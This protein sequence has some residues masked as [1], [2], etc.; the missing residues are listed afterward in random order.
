MDK[1]KEMTERLEQ[2]MYG[3]VPYNISPIQQG[4]QF[5]HAVVEYGLENIIKND[6]YQQWARNDKTFIILN[7][8]TT[9]NN[10][11][12]Y[13]TLNNAKINLH[14]LGVEIATFHEPDLGDQLT[15][16]VFLVDE[17]IYDYAKYPTYD[18]IMHEVGET[19]YYEN[20]FGKEYEKV[21]DMRDFLSQYKLA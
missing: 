17:R 16:I 18:Y 11:E 8:G 5:G 13:G 6:A 15:A 14:S 12:R 4:I 7:G 19:T 2:R 21:L 3:L 10:K 20:L 9:N 1:I